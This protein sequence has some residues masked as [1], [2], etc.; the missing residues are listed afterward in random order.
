M[1]PTTGLHL[2]QMYFERIL[3]CGELENFG[4]AGVLTSPNWPSDYE[5]NLD[6]SYT[7]SVGKELTNRVVLKFI[8]FEI[9]PHEN[10][11]FD[12]LEVSCLCF[13]YNGCN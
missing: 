4:S 5:N 3:G 13:G 11:R 9:E 6:C 2:N 1:L 8:F 12:Y 10:C 7:I